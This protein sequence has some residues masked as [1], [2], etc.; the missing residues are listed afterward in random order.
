MP[1][2]S[3]LDLASPWPHLASTRVVVVEL[4]VVGVMVVELG[5]VGVVVVEFR[6]V[7][8]VEIVKGIAGG[9]E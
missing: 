9:D 6:V 1:P 5:V 7:D 2:T 4:G 3:S 8:V